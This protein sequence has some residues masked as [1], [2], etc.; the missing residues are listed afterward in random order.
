MRK[1]TLAI[2]LVIL[3]PIVAI[4]WQIASADINNAEF[5]GD[6]RYIATQTSVNIGLTS[7]K[8]DDQVREDII[9]AAA[10]DGIHLEPDQIKLQRIRSGLYIRFNLA[11]NYTIPVNLLV[12]SFNL[13]FVQ[14]IAK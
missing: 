11:V 5:H 9:A 8:T 4:G 12:D 13:H 2:A 7:P 6:L 10:E 14:T 3:T 1:R